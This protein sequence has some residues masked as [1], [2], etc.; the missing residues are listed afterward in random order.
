MAT[1]SLSQKL[2]ILAGLGPRAL[3]GEDTLEVELRRHDRAGFGPLARPDYP[4]A[5]EGVDDPACPRITDPETA[6]HCA[7]RGLLRRYYEA[8]RL[9]QKLVVWLFGRFGVF[10]RL[11]HLLDVA[12]L[13]APAA[14]G[15]RRG[16]HP[17]HFALGDECALHA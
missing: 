1:I 10:F 2:P 8:R 13:D 7:D 9:R 6:L 17:L 11:R 5:L 16:D 12:R 14:R 3:F 4:L 15:S